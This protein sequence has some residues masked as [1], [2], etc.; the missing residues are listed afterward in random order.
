MRAWHGREGTGGK[1]GADDWAAAQAEQVA[2]ERAAA[3][4]QQMAV[5]GV[6]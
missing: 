2:D 5:G 1:W 3:M 6:S 4:A